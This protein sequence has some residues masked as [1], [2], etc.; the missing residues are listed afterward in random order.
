MLEIK[1]GKRDMIKVSEVL[2]S[3]LFKVLE[4]SDVNCE[5]VKE[6]TWK[7]MRNRRVI[8]KKSLKRKSI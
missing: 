2:F 7:Q 5:L 4:K 3:I 1:H 6:L 8:E